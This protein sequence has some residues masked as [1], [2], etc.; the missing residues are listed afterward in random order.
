M[1]EYLKCRAC[2]YIMDKK[3]APDICPACGA[4]SKAFE[5][6]KYNVSERRRIIMSIDIHPIILH[7]PQAASAL[8]PFFIIMSFLVSAKYSVRLVFAAEILIYILPVS[9]LAAFASGIFDGHNRFR[10]ITTPALKKKMILGT[11]LF[12]V[13]CAMPLNIYIATIGAAIPS[14]LILSFLSLAIQAALARIGIKLMY[15]HMPG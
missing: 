11:A 14:L 2:N 6:Y 7:I 8:I 13:T 4:V 9:V 3:N 5:N 1:K 12:I 10:K 15:A